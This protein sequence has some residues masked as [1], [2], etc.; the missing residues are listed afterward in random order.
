MWAKSDFAGLRSQTSLT[1]MTLYLGCPIWAHKGWVGNFFPKGTKSGDFLREYSR[2]LNTVEG[3][4]TFYAA[5]TPATL[6]RWKN[7]TP[8]GFHFCPKL[9][10]TVSHAG[11]LVPRLDEA[12]RF[13]DLMRALGSRLGPLFLQLPPRYS[14]GHMEDLRAFLAGWPTDLKLAVEVRHPDWFQP[15]H[16]EA[17]N[18]LLRE[19]DSARVL[20]DT[21]PIRDMPEVVIADG[22]VQVRT[23]QARERK[24]DV[25]LMP[26]RTASFTF[27]RY[28]G[29][30]K[31]ELNAPFLEE[32]AERAAGWLKEGAEVYVFCH[33]PDETHSPQFCRELHR[34]VATRVKV[35]PLPWEDLESREV[36]EKGSRGEGEQGRLL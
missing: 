26:V 13:I 9:P 36:G 6:E 30:P 27:L 8:E 17:L 33:C 20:I 23:E 4:T 32:W 12:R 11:K 28:V 16:N 21:R 15:P 10:R 14:P 7:D 3:N 18:A 22:K 35:N 24:P 1:R 2:R 31:V 34:R 5:P 29:H 19:F 25:P